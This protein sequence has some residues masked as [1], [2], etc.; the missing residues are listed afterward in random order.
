M[1]NRPA[2]PAKKVTPS[3]GLTSVQKAARTASIG[4]SDARIICNGK[5]EEIERLWREKRGELTP[6]DIEFFA[7]L[8]DAV[9]IQFGHFS[10]NFNRSWFEKRTGYVVTRVGEAIGSPVGDAFPTHVSLDGFLERLDPRDLGGTDF[11]LS[12]TCPKPK[13]PV[14]A[15]WEAKWRNANQFDAEGQVRN[16]LPQLHVGMLRTSTDHAVL[17]TLTGNLRLVCRV[18]AFDDAYWRECA[19]RLAAF[20]E[21]VMSGNAPLKRESMVKA[22]K[23][24]VQ[25]TILRTVD[26][27]GETCANAWVFY[28]GELLDTLPND[29]EAKKAAR[30]DKARS[31]LKA[32]V[33]KDIGTA[34]GAGIEAKRD[35]KGALSFYKVEGGK[36]TRI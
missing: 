25:K 19:I 34:R 11:E 16:F 1:K 26:M 33:A 28:A 31:E 30:H 2:P 4:A 13:A 18:V 5:D 32:L 14:R 8:D 7:A 35:A 6:Q 21:A 20:H 15:V 22:G 36:T 3:L 24:T 10:E 17:S 12:W 27:T 23:T 29:A 9:E